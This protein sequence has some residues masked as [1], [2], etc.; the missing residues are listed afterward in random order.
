MSAQIQRL[1]I[2][3]CD[4]KLCGETHSFETEEE[5]YDVAVEQAFGDAQAE[6]WGGE[7]EKAYCPRHAKRKRH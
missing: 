3:S 4:A 5:D 2:I 6:G 1:C 7:P